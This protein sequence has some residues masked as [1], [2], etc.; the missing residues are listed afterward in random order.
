MDDTQAQQTR[1]IGAHQSQIGIIGDHAHIEGGIHF[2]AP[3]LSLTD[4]RNRNSMLQ[5][6]HIFWVQGVLEQSL[7]GG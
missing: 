3:S 1:K 6:V 2:H 5:L 7:H 4:L